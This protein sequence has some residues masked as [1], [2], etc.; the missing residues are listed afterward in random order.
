MMIIVYNQPVAQ[1]D[2]TCATRSNNT[3]EN[4]AN[5]GLIDYTLM[6][7]RSTSLPVS[8]THESEVYGSDMLGLSPM[9][10]GG[11]YN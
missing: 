7:E 2:F 4:Q 10:G 9:G 3:Q 11:A 1:R 6:Q 5:E 8:S